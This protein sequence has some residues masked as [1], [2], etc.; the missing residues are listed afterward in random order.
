[1]NINERLT[2][3]QS[4]PF[5]LDLCAQTCNSEDQHF[6][7]SQRSLVAQVCVFFHFLPQQKRIKEKKDRRIKGNPTKDFFRFFFS[8]L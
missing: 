7:M 2:D 5:F 1:M 8:R 6:V 4:L 3:K